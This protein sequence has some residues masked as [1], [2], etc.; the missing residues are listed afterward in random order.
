MATPA[1]DAVTDFIVG[2]PSRA[3]PAPVVDAARQC[4]LDWFAA[5]AAAY[6]HPGPRGVARLM[7]RWKSQ[8]QALTFYGERGAAGPVALVN[9][10]LAHMLDFDDVHLGTASHIGA[11]VVAAALALGMDRSADEAG[12]L[13]AIVVGY[14]V[15]AALG[16]TGLGVKL[17]DKAWHPTSILDHFAAAAAAA[18]LI[19]LDAEKTRH[20]IGAAATQASGLMAAGGSIAK[21]FH[22]GKSA[23]N[24]ILAA[25]AAELG[26]TSSPALIDHPRTGLFAALLAEGDVPSAAG[27]GETWQILTN[28]YKPY[29]AC[30]FTHAPYE[31]AQKLR[32]R[33]AGETPAGFRVFVHPLAIKVA[34]H[35]RPQTPIQAKF[36]IA[37]GVALG[38]AGGAMRESDFSS[39]RMRDREIGQISERVELVPDP[40]LA[41]WGARVEM[42]RGD[43]SVDTEPNPGALGSPEN[44]MRWPDLERKFALYAEPVFGADAAEMQACLTGFDTP[45]SLARLAAILERR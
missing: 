41:R 30:Q 31:A 36:S 32:A 8:G 35:M 20:A 16:G 29:P 4:L 39:D 6:H 44:P 45:G 11:S 5:C 14:E 26:L 37:Y 25:E 28:A 9:G 15:A 43:G 18:C 34:G 7:S 27:L 24:G 10:T 23:M 12:I 38:Y 40:G 13:K 2:A 33:A 22:V 3:L 1:L 19:G 17:A 42:R 21:P